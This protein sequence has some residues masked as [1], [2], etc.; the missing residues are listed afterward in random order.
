M[1]TPGVLAGLLAPLVVRGSDAAA[2]A[3]IVHQDAILAELRTI[4]GD[5]V[6]FIESEVLGAIPHQSL[7]EKISAGEFAAFVRNLASEIA[8]QLPAG[9]A[10]VLNAIEAQLEALSAKLAGAD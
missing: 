2:N 7:S 4:E 5:A 10:A 1:A 3:L 8:N 9:N 6:A